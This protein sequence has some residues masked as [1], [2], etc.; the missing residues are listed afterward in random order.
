MSD[1]C[2]RCSNDLAE[3]NGR[4]RIACES[5]NAEIYG[6]CS[7]SCRHD[8]ILKC[9]HCTNIEAKTSQPNAKKP[10]KRRAYPKG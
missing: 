10:S 1:K 3:V 6:I 4:L 2:A 5:C 8:K 9:L 7:C